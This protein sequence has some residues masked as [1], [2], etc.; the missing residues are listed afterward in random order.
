[1]VVKI[2]CKKTGVPASSVTKHYTTTYYYPEDRS[3][4][5]WIVQDDFDLR[6]QKDKYTYPED[7]PTD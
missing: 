4:K 1:M 2:A 7:A 6:K 5:D 3:L